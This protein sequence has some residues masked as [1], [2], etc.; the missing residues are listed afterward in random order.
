MGAN[1]FLFCLFADSGT[2]RHI[3]D[4]SRG[5]AIRLCSS[6]GCLK[7][8]FNEDVRKI[9]RGLEKLKTYY[10]ERDAPVIHFLIKC[11]SPSQC[12]S[13]TLFSGYFCGT[14][15]LYEFLKER[16][17]DPNCIFED[18][19]TN[20]RVTAITTSLV[21]GNRNAFHLLLRCGADVNFVPRDAMNFAPTIHF[22]LH[23]TCANCRKVRIEEV[24]KA[25]AD[26][27]LNV[28]GLGTP[29][30]HARDVDIVEL[31]KYGADHRV[32]P[33][34]YTK[35]TPLLIMLS[36]KTEDREV[37]RKESSYLNDI[38][39]LL[40]VGAAPPWEVCSDDFTRAVLK[41][42]APEEYKSPFVVDVIMRSGFH[43]SNLGSLAG[44]D[45]EMKSGVTELREKYLNRPRSL[46]D[47]CAAV[48]RTEL[49]PNALCGTQKLVEQ[50]ILPKALGKNV[51]F[52]VGTMSRF[53]WVSAC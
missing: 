50:K 37:F 16:A 27:N 5:M 40:A 49:K 43:P 35:T 48:I 52:H 42:A 24:M 18:E 33:V 3:T 51:T 19:D 13:R 38:C 29:L 14:E 7:R 8:Y 12:C 4:F 36:M 15:A 21:Y 47:L 30:H 46:Q 25:G 44:D 32:S 2:V 41:R 22:F 20:V 23:S 28:K 10:R 17:A 1:S 26:A 39:L 11:F 53:D 6:D 34:G 9:N 31:A 45:E